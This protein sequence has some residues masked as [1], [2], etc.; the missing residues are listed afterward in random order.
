[1]FTEL[2]VWAPFKIKKGNALL[3]LAAHSM[4][5]A[6]VSDFSNRTAM[7][8]KHIP[9]SALHTDDRKLECFECR[10]GNV[11]NLKNEK[12]LNFKCASHVEIPIRKP[13][14]FKQAERKRKQIELKRQAQAKRFNKEVES[15]AGFLSDAV[16]AG[17][18]AA[19]I[20]VAAKISFSTSPSLS[21]RKQPKPRRQQQTKLSS[22]RSHATRGNATDAEC[23]S[24]PAQTTMR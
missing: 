3:R 6:F 24:T 10:T 11:L 19:R 21:H 12:A 7:T 16:D 22:S 15:K 17:M 18:Q 9:A 23:V 5:D 14:S 8:D 13:R 20:A 1:M 4:P 2:H